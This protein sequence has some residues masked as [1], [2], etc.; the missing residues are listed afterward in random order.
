M[1]LALLGFLAV[2]GGTNWYIAARLWRWLGL[3]SGGWLWAICFAVLAT[4]FLFSQFETFMPLKLS[5]ALNTVGGWYL[6][7]YLILLLL[8]PAADLL[9]RGG[10]AVAA[11]LL[12]LAAC[13]TA[14]GV[15]NARRIVRTDYTVEADIPE[16]LTLALISDVHLGWI[17]DAKQ[18]APMI[19]AVNAADADYVLLAGDTLDE[20]PDF[21][22]D[23]EAAGREFARL[24]AKRGIYACLGNHDGAFKGQE[25]AA[26]QL[27]TRWGV[28]VLRDEVALD[29]AV[30]IAGRKDDAERDRMPCDQLF[31]EIDKEKTFTV[32]L[33]HQPGSFPEEKAAGADL[34]L[35][36]HTHNG[37]MFPFGLATGSIYH[38]DY[39]RKTEDGCTMIVS[40][41]IGT[42][43]PRIRTGCHAE[44]AVIRLTPGK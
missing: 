40:S 22:L 8:V 37:Q 9:T 32:L 38:P 28:R 29:G 7:S 33:D 21:V 27:L 36:G 26:Q 42:W 23:K 15:W 18:L 39:G 20:G 19:D 4:A 34:I 44:V 11:V 25:D 5:K 16:P 14:Y 12:L 24:R 2:Y 30:A 6:Q 35:C 1:L 41:G 13:V 3:T 17:I 43:G 10:P 31:K